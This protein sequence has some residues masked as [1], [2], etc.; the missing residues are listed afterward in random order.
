M[1]APMPTLLQRFVAAVNGGD[2]KAFL[3]LFGDDSIVTDWG[4]RYVGI[5]AISEWNDREMIGAKGT[6]T[7]SDV[8]TKPNEIIF[9]G[10]WASSVFTGP[11]RFVLKLDG[12]RIREMRISE[13]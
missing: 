5:V 8:A 11:G 7:V 2:S 9:R 10:D 3:A 4:D 6:L 12:E 13:A 1:T